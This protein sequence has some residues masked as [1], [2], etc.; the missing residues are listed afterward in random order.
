MSTA[1]DRK[2]IRLDRETGSNTVD[3]QCS[4][5]VTAN[6]K[7]YD[8]DEELCIEDVVRKWRDSLSEAVT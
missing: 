8:I 5:T 2:Y 3:G 7:T 6:P 4:G 1:S